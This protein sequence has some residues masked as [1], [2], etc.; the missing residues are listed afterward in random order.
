MDD[1]ELCKF[2]NRNCFRSL[3]AANPFK[4]LK[5]VHIIESLK[6]VYEF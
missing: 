5:K 6:A 1:R 3:T 2:L 4:V